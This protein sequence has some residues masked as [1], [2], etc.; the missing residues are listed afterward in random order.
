[1]A[2]GKT[3]IRE[4]QSLEL[5]TKMEEFPAMPC[6]ERDQVCEECFQALLEHNGQICLIANLYTLDGKPCFGFCLGLGGI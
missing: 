6:L 2:R 4:T 5:L 1:M 3:D